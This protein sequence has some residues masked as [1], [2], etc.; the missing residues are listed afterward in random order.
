[1]SVKDQGRVD[2]VRA[3]DGAV[4]PGRGTNP[5]EIGWTSLGQ[6]LCDLADLEQS[7]SNWV[8]SIV[9]ELTQN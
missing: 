7:M 6:F 5:G 4:L 2:D 3:G 1:M 9:E 8:I